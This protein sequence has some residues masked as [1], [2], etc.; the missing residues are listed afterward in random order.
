MDAIK[1]GMLASAKAA[2]AAARLGERLFC[3]NTQPIMNFKSQICTTKK[4][5]ERLLALGLKKETADCYYWQECDQY[6]DPNGKWHLDILNDDTRGHFE[7]LLNHFGIC[8]HLEDALFIPAWS[9]HRLI[10]MMP[11]NIHK[12]ND[13]ADLSVSNELVQYRFYDVDY[14]H[15]VC[16]EHFNDGTLYDNI[17]DCIEWLI[18]EG[19]FNKQYLEE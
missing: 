4:Q 8:L 9:L 5:S 12:Y 17:I 16:L 7:Y 11:N 15:D 18:K 1:E 19:Y 13:I 6:G 14:N 3:Q 10:E 2:E